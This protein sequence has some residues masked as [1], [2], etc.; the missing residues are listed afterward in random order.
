MKRNI[1]AALLVFSL[2]FSQSQVF[3]SV[4]YSQR[5]SG[6]STFNRSPRPPMGPAVIHATPPVIV[7]PPARPVVRYAPPR[8]NVIY[9][10]NTRPYY[11]SDY[12]SGYYPG[13]Y[14]SYYPGYYNYP[15]TTTT[16]TI[17][18]SQPPVVVMPSVQPVMV[19][20][21]T[22]VTN[23]TPVTEAVQSTV[24]P[25][26]IEQAEETVPVSFVQQQGYVQPAYSETIT[27]TVVTDNREKADK[28]LDRT[29]KAVGIAGVASLIGL[30]V[31]V[32]I[33]A[34]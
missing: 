10:G 22:P 33:R 7:R 19:N 31:A 5:A 2:L 34:L 29:G 25:T 4:N 1:F 11:S 15:T 30:G 27:T 21:I 18:V 28:I 20:G 26:L 6:H 16:Q 24:Y 13:Y 14:T 23:I 17:V 3:A 12:Y 32:L 9:V 8:T